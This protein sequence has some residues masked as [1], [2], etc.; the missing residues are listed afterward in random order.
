MIDRE[1]LDIDQT[2]VTVAGITHSAVPFTPISTAV[3]SRI[4]GDVIGIH[5]HIGPR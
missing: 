2:A 5:C 3:F 1:V 4:R